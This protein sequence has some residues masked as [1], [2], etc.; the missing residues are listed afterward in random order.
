M[1]SFGDGR[2]F[3][4]GPGQVPS[5]LPA[6]WIKA[7]QRARKIVLVT[8]DLGFPVTGPAADPA[9]LPVDRIVTRAVCGAIPVS[10]EGT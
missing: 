4:W 1:V 5:G 8:G 2:R 3:L 7:A 6:G 9:A 10:Q